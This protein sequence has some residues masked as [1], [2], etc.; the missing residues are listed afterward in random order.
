V[1]RRGGDADAQATRAA[2]RARFAACLPE[3]KP[4][5]PLHLAVSS[6]KLEG[7][8]TR[9]RVVAYAVGEAADFDLPQYVMSRGRWLINDRARSYLLDE[10]CREYRLKDRKMTLGDVPT[11]GRVRLGAGESCEFTLVFPRL[12]DEVYHGALVYGGWTLPFYVLPEPP[13]P[14]LN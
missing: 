12:P 3:R 11:G 2:V 4:E 8:D 13:T 5:G 7:E 10:G 1:R 14:P 6:L 9:V